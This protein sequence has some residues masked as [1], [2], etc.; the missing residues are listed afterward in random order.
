MEANGQHS[1]TRFGVFELNTN[2]GELRKAG[3]RIRIQDQPLKI[4]MALLEQPGAVVTRQELKRRIWPDESFGD[5]DHAVNVAVAKLRAALSDSADTPRFV[6]TL[7]RRGYRFIF[8]VTLPAEQPDAVPSNGSAVKQSTKASHFTTWTA[9]GAV[10]LVAVWAAYDG[11]LFHR[12]TYALTDKDTI[13]VADFTN[14]T[15]DPVFDGTLRQGLAVQLD[16]SPFLSLISDERVKQTLRLMSQPPD[17]SL[18]P[19]IAQQV[20]LR[21]GSAAVL[22]GSIANLG[23]QYVLGL[24]AVNCTTGDTLGEEQATADGKEQVLKTLEQTAARLRGKLGESLMTVEKFNTPVEEVTTPSLDALQAYSL[25]RI[26][27][28]DKEDPLGAIQLFRRAIEL[29]PNFAMAY[30]SLGLAYSEHSEK[31]STANYRIAYEL[32]DRVSDRERFY[33]ESHYYESVTG[34]L[35]KARQVYEVWEKTYPRDDIAHFNL[36]GNALNLGDFEKAEEEAKETLKLLRSDCLS[37]GNLL[38]AYINMN[39]LAEAHAVANEA[40]ERKADC[41]HFQV[42]R[43]QLA[44]LEGDQAGMA[45]MVAASAGK[46]GVG[47]LGAEAKT[48]AYYGQLKQSREYV[49][50]AISSGEHGGVK[51]LPRIIEAWDADSEALLGNAELARRE[52]NEALERSSGRDVQGIAALA[53]ALTG[54][55]NRAQALAESLAK[56]FP[57]DTIVQRNYL[58]TI[59][60]QL[61]L[62]R[63]D[64][65]KAI[66]VLKTAHPYELATMEGSNTLYSVFLRGQ[67]CLMARDGA[68]AMAEFQ[69]IIDHRGIVLYQIIGPLAHLGLA[70]AYALQG[71]SVKARTA[72]QDFLTLWKDADADIPVLK[73]ARTEFAKLAA[74]P[75]VVASRSKS[76]GW[77][78]HRAGRQTLGSRDDDGSINSMN[79]LPKFTFS[80][81]TRSVSQ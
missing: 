40:E 70:R 32:R 41:F 39:R 10:L 46:W 74:N 72:Y 25:G 65:S 23:N 26:T 47:S 43:Y 12:K 49:R 45:R 33:I 50:Q 19:Q 75:Q 8:P 44:F 17:A 68:G 28:V 78:N 71:D 36:S 3:T 62:D 80:P 24:R 4:L 52:A 31:D 56:R 34:N 7:H 67:A 1:T 73:Q 79:R 20:C 27:L 37:Y 61:A 2:S 54:D 69:K 77:T 16:Q 22:E 30:A 18:T 58:P 64:S 35:E 59:R 60:A 81:E 14:T 6:E 15:G 66:E 76:S 57:Q 51:E 53:L 29:D 63:K 11:W 38:S 42:Y 5:F 13:V 55:A 21:T 48:A 9:I